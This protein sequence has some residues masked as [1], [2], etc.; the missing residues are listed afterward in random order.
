[1]YARP[2]LCSTRKTMLHSVISA[3]KK[4]QLCEFP[5]MKQRGQNVRRRYRDSYFSRNRDDS[6][7]IVADLERNTDIDYNCT[8]CWLSGLFGPG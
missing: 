1:M 8:L 2:M 4:L 6:G 7:I 3:S 5:N